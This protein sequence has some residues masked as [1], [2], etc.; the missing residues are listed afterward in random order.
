MTENERQRADELYKKLRN[1]VWSGLAED[2]KL[3]YKCPF[4][5]MTREFCDLFRQ[6]TVFGHRRSIC[7]EIFKVEG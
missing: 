6:K 4:Y 1:L 5:G 7:Q 2:R 3:C